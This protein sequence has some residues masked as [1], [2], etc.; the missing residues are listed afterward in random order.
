MA[1]DVNAFIQRLDLAPAARGSLEG[2]TFGVKDVIDVAGVVTGCGNPTWAK[3]HAPAERHA[4]VVDLLLNSGA[5][6]LGKTITDEFAFSLVGEN[7]F[8]GTPLNPKAPDRIPG[9]SSSGSASAVAAAEVDFAIGTDTA[10]SIRVPAANCG[11]YG[12]RPTWGQSPMAGVQALAPSFDTVGILARDPAL[13][14]R[15]ADCLWPTLKPGPP[16]DTIFLLEE[17]WALIDS[18][19]RADL[20]ARL[21]LGGR[22]GLKV[23]SIRLSAIHDGELGSDIFAWKRAFSAVQWPEVWDTF[24][25][26]IERTAP[27]MGPKIVANFD[28]TRK[29]DRGHFAEAVRIWHRARN[30]LRSFLQPGT[31][32]GLPTVPSPPPLRGHVDYDRTGTGYLARTLCLTAFAGLGGLPQINLPFTTRSGLPVGLSLMAGPDADLAL[33]SVVEALLQT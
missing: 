24:G 27:E 4:A 15:L 32:L 5:R 12:M 11:L 20:S 18:D 26:W 33:I 22:E 23:K 6:C 21:P 25:S 28:L 10:G 17:A 3:T 29:Y 8:Y 9:G 30:A 16:I 31:A 1:D 7:H 14:R 13:L 19:L 2:L